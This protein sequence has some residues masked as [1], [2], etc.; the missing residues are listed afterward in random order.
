MRGLG[1]GT[2]KTCALWT[3]MW[4]AEGRGGQV[5]TGIWIIGYGVWIIVIG[6]TPTP[7]TAD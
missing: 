3:C 4:K 2:A 5:L 1:T 7:P 6:A